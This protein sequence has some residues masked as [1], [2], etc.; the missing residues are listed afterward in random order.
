MMTEL[1]FLCELFPHDQYQSI[2]DWY[3]YYWYMVDK[4]NFL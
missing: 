4:S 2:K 1:A 3:Q